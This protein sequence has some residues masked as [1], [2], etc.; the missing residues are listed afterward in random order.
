MKPVIFTG[1]PL[2]SCQYFKRSQSLLFYFLD[3]IFCDFLKASLPEVNRPS[4]E[5]K[6]GIKNAEYFFFPMQNGNE[7]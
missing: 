7:W 2:F 1:F 3:N 5:G 6:L 4:F